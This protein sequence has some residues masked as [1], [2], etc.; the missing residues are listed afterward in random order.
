MSNRV[1]LLLLSLQFYRAKIIQTDAHFALVSF[2]DYGN[3][4]DKVPY[5]D[6]RPLVS[7]FE[8]K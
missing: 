5:A 4:A 6:L 2:I 3:D 1:K 8:R 7:R